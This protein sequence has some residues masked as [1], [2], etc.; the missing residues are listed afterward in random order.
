MSKPT[1][2]PPATPATILDTANRVGRVAVETRAGVA[3]LQPLL[4]LLQEPET[5]GESPIDEL[6][7]LLEAILLS[8]RQIHLLVEDLSNRVDA[9]GRRRL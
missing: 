1:T 5:D 9:L 4:T 2:P 3:A 7:D 6:R 8:Q